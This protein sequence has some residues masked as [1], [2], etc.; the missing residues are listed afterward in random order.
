MFSSL[1]VPAADLAWYNPDSKT[2]EIERMQYTVW[3][4]PS[5]NPRQLLSRPFTIQD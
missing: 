4:G 2:W 3:V 5:S 1:S